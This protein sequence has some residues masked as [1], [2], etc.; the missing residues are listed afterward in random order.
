MRTSGLIAVAATRDKLVDEHKRIRREHDDGVDAIDALE[1]RLAALERECESTSVLDRM[2]QWIGAAEPAAL[3]READ[4]VRRELTEHSERL[5]LIALQEQQIAARLAEVEAA[6]VELSRLEEA[7]VADLLASDGPAGDELRHIRED[8][9]RADDR[10]ASLTRLG[11]AADRGETAIADIRDIV[12]AHARSG[13]FP[14][15]AAR[16]H[17][18]LSLEELGPS[19]RDLARARLREH[20]GFVQ[21]ELQTLRDAFVAC[22][23]DVDT[24]ARLALAQLDAL[25]AAPVLEPPER[26]KLVAGI[27]SAATCVARLIDVMNVELAALRRRRDALVAQQR[28]VE[29]RAL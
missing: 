14:E 6:R 4:A 20:I 3:R 22:R 1:Q 27:Q 24:A 28:I 11:K 13:S 15:V 16:V 9:A 19:D 2:K 25:I 7:R 26:S 23:L 29:G 12:A 10:I 5:A 18:V 8:L 21:H 17:T